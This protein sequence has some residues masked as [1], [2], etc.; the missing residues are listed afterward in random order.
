MNPD[1]RNTMSK[2]IDGFV[3]PIPKDKLEKYTEVATKAGAIWKDHGALEYVE[4]VGD[5]HE[6]E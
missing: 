5:D 6:G 4:A 1:P 2:Y 3:L